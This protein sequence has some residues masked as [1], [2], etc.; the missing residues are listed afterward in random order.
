MTDGEITFNMA[1]F[2]GG[3]WCNPDSNF[4]MTGGVVAENEAVKGVRHKKG[5]DKQ[6]FIK[7]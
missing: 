7:V 6:N 1:A 2:G 3:V 4:K 5:Y